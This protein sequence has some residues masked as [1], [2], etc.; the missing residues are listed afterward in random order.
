MFSQRF[1]IYNQQCHKCSYIYSREP[2]LSVSV[3]LLA[4]AWAYLTPFILSPS[5]RPM[6][7]DNKSHTISHSWS[8]TN[9]GIIFVSVALYLYIPTRWGK[10][11]C[12]C[13]ENCYDR[14][15]NHIERTC[16][17]FTQRRML[18][19]GCKRISRTI[20]KIIVT[21]ARLTSMIGCIFYAHNITLYSMRQ[22]TSNDL[23]KFYTLQETSESC[24]V[25]EKT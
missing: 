22:S 9:F 4:L 7:A 8:H 10:C 21:R 2:S 6:K 15:P 20:T 13:W 5:V 25:T 23:Y 18:K 19:S 24:E 16:F 11:L 12:R 1:V 14:L 17:T 3:S